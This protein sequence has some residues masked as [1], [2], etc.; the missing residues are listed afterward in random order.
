MV[1]F[2]NPPDQI[3][4]PLSIKAEEEREGE[5][6]QGGTEGNRQ[7]G[8]GR[9]EWKNGAKTS[10][11]LFDDGADSKTNTPRASVCASVCV[12]VC[13]CVCAC[14]RMSV[15]LCAGSETESEG[16]TMERERREREKVQADVCIHSVGGSRLFA[17]D[18]ETR[19]GERERR[20]KRRRETE[21]GG[22]NETC[23]PLILH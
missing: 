15:C 4:Y 11:T 20:E 16:E 14:V 1:E 13:V 17:E 8:G 9:V 2:K 7:E 21:R 18:G 3:I 10:L 5:E 22:L 19:E 23:F 12:C 6:D